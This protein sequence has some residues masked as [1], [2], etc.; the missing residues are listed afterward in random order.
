MHGIGERVSLRSEKPTIGII[1]VAIAVAS[2]GDITYGKRATWRTVLAIVLRALHQSVSRVSF[3]QPQ[4]ESHFRRAAPRNH[5]HRNL[6]RP[7]V[8]G[9]DT[10]TAFNPSCASFGIRRDHHLPAVHAPAYRASLA[11]LGRGH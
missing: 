10:N 7:C 1:D 3:D 6:A 8:S 9:A 2:R 4:G 5:V 11:E